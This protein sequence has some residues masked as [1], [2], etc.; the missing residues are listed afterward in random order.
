M[1]V[2][3]TPNTPI[4]TVAQFGSIGIPY[5]RKI[6]TINGRIAVNPEKWQNV[7]PSETMTKGMSVGLRI[8]SRIFSTVVGGGCTHFSLV[9]EHEI[10][11][12]ENALWRFN[13]LNSFSTA[14]GDTQPRSHCKDFCA[15]LVRSFDSSHSGVSGIYSQIILNQWS[16]SHTYSKRM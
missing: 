1:M 2:P 11:A 8:N 14:C 15:S 4:Q 16:N 3:I 9:F 6:R 5:T 12:L 13:S 7:Y 10:Q